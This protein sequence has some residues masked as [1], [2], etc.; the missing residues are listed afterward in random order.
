[1]A[2]KGN[3]LTENFEQRLAIPFESIVKWKNVEY[4]DYQTADKCSKF[5]QQEDF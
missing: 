4:K 2:E 3:C 5:V 1:M